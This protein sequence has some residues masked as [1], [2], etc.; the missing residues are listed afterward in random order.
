[1]VAF[2]AM[3][4]TLYDARYHLYTSSRFRSSL[5][6]QTAYIPGVRDDLFVYSSHIQ[7][8]KMPITIDHIKFGFEFESLFLM[9]VKVMYDYVHQCNTNRYDF[10]CE[11]EADCENLNKHVLTGYLSDATGCNFYVLNDHLKENVHVSCPYFLCSKTQKGC[12]VPPKL[13]DAKSWIVG[14]DMS[15]CTD[16]SVDDVY[17]FDDVRRLFHMYNVVTYDVDEVD[18]IIVSDFGMVNENPRAYKLIENIEITSPIMSFKYVIHDFKQLFQKINVVTKYNAINDDDDVSYA[19]PMIP[20]NTDVTSNHIHLSCIHNSKNVFA[21][22]V[23]THK[24]CMAWW[25]FEPIILLLVGHWRRNNGYCVTMRELFRKKDIGHEKQFFF[26]GDINNFYQGVD[27]N[28][29]TDIMYVFQG[30]ITKDHR[31]KALNLIPLLGIGTIEVRIKHGSYD[32]EEN[33]NFILLFGLLMRAAVNNPCVCY[34]FGGDKIHC[35]YEIYDKL[36][37]N[38]EFF[39]KTGIKDYDLNARQMITLC[40]QCLFDFLAPPNTE[41]RETYEAVCLFII[42]R[43]K[44][45]HLSKKV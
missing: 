11:N 35:L 23:N 36:K 5:N 21:D 3:H 8:H 16:N 17:Y 40:L 32:A 10:Q 25:Y 13:P 29:L 19:S 34:F 18:T 12:N 31:Y 27:P 44:Q 9:N 24:I 7:R 15:V 43:V 33:V 45:L 4:Q 1:M 42:N 39:Q 28:R 30:G 2:H 20:F 37:Q 14:R 26:S 22:P 6:N 41:N 38:G